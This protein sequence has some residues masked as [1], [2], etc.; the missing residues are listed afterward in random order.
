[1]NWR[2]TQSDKDDHFTPSPDD[3]YKFPNTTAFPDFA[4]NSTAW[5]DYLKSEKLRT[6]CLY[7]LHRLDF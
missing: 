3:Y 4:G 1:M 5:F 7:S 2:D 6:C